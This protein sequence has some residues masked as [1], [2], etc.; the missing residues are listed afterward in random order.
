MY[1]VVLDNAVFSKVVH[2]HNY[3]V[4]SFDYICSYVYYIYINYN[5]IHIYETH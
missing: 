5:A 4:A 2:K 3:P 1:N